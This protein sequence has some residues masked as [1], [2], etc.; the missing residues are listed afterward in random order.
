MARQL[1][2]LALEPFFGGVRRSMLE[3]LVRY[4]RHR[5]TVLKL[6]PRRIE[7]RLT[8]A[9]NWFAEQL[10]RHWVG[11]MDLL[12]TSEAMNLASLLRM[13]PQLAA[14]PSVVY[15]HDNQLPD[16]SLR[17]ASGD[18]NSLDLVNLNT[19]QAATEIWFNSSYHKQMFFI[20]AR[21]LIERHR[22]LST[23]DPIPELVAKARLFCPPVDLNLIHELQNSSQPIE[24]KARTIF[25][26]T[27]D[28]D[29]QL[30][31]HAIAK[32]RKQHV[33]F[34][35]IT[36]GPVDS[37]DPAVERT[38][39]SEYDEIGQT[40]GMFASST[41]VSVKPN[42]A[43][44]YL[45]VRAL[46]A[47]CRPVLPDAG[48][49]PELLPEPLHRAALYAVDADPLADHIALAIGSNAPAWKP[50]DAKPALKAFD[51]MTQCRLIDERIEQIVTSHG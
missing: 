8:A 6:P 45:V 31:N 22:E 20:F 23:H 36:V 7:R 17:A 11:R 44:D 1:D 10:G 3:A 50:Q 24:R 43:S 9:A 49:Y 4:S 39:V 26:E 18:D 25:V 46:A 2:I 30:L 21:A 15:F 47:G 38:T 14:A 48:V 40:R 37:L 27:R 16:L 51:A 41:I 34:N 5:W 35:L 12:F 19:A 42:A 13:M 29:V 33:P 32:L 28:A